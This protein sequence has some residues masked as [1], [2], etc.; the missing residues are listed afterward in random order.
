MKHKDY[1]IGDYVVIHIC[2]ECFFIDLFKKFHAQLLT[3]IDLLVL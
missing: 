2:P 3:L 1:H